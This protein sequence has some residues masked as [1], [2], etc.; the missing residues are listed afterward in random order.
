MKNLVRKISLLFILLSVTLIVIEILL[1]NIP[2]EYAY[3]KKYLDN[4]SNNTQI[5][6]IGASDAEGGFNPI[7][8]T[9][10]SFNAAHP[11]QSMDYCYEILR[12]YDN[13]WE[14][15]EYIVLAVSYPSLFMKLGQVSFEGWRI[16]DY[17]IYYKIRINKKIKYYAEIFNGRLIYHFDRLF[18]YYVK[19]KDEIYCSEQ[20]WYVTYYSPPKDSLIK[21]GIKRAH[22][23]T[24]PKD[25]Q[26][27]DE[28]KSAIDS[29]IGFSKKHKCKVILCTPPLY[30][31][32]IENVDKYQYDLTFNTIEKL[33]RENDN[34]IYINFLNDP[35]FKDEDF[36]DG[37]HLN[38]YGAKKMTLVIDSLINNFN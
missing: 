3:K 29:I 31:S 34:C 10:R 23:L 8:T 37:D 9:K 27:F 16:K 5:V 36:M 18:L 26:R 33:A 38:G 6:F 30:W 35:R 14:K 24:I 13:K 11:A 1:R 20:G 22:I 2:N 25:Q 4:E 15:L 7:Y 12:K 32:Y 19:N 17:I 28:M 21:A